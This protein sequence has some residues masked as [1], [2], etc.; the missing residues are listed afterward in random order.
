[1]NLASGGLFGAAVRIVPFTKYVLGR[2]VFFLYN[3]K[4]V[5][6]ADR[7]ERLIYHTCMVDL[8]SLVAQ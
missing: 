6:N 5:S 7:L 8:R 4:A 2:G 3:S 1:M